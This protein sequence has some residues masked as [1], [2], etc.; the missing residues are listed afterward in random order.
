MWSKNQ[1]HLHSLLLIVV[2]FLF[3]STASAANPESDILDKGRNITDG[4]TLVSPGGS[5][6]LGFFPPGV[7]GKRYLGIWFSMDE[8]AICWVAN[9]DHPLTDARGVLVISDT[10]SLLL[11]DSSGQVVWS[12]N[13]TGTA[14]TTVQLLE[15]GNLVSRDGNAS[16]AIT[17]Q[18][19]DHPSNTLLPGMKIGKNLWTGEEWYLTS[20]RSADDPATGNFRYITDTEG[21]PQNVMLDG[22]KRIYRTGPWN[23]LWFSGVTEMGT[24]SDMFI[25]RLTSSPSEITYGYVAKAGTPFS[26]L[27]LTDD[28]LFRRLVWDTSSRAWK[29]FFQGP[30]DICDQYGRCG[31][32]G[33]CNAS[34][35]S[36]SFCS[37]VRGF[38]PASPVQWKMRDTSNGCRRNVTL[39]CGNGISTTDGF[40]VMQGV[41]LPD[42]H[43]ASVDASITLEECRTRCLAN[44]SCLAYAPLDLKGGGTGTGCIIWREDLMDLRHVDGGQSLFLRSAK[45]ELGEAQPPKSFPTGIVIGVT[46][47]LVTII[48]ALV[49]F[50]FSPWRRRWN[51]E[52]ILDNPPRVV[53]NAPR[54]VDNVAPD[55]HPPNLAL[56]TTSFPAVGLPAVVQATGNFSE[57]NIIGKG[58]FSVI[59]KVL[60]ISCT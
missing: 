53:H 40:V 30:R 20:W 19:F 44:C 18:S 9:R 37:C 24:Y 11:I 14:S 56:L 4:E 15:S 3:V 47:P 59:Y 35:P 58:G 39:D 42:T 34:A 51:R 16:G 1:P 55:S 46:V 21:V 48:L 57:A 36:T 33:L 38:S 60:I 29:I 54:V 50:W 52:R 41:K 12:S 49:A 7:L 25:Y 45:S 6:T 10:R 22:G 2:P 26:R 27:V 17:W 32:F 13:T 5:F 23:G 28:G 43:N 31:A 8:D